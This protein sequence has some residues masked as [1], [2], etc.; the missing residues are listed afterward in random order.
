[1]KLS[2]FNG[3]HL[4]SQFELPASHTLQ[5][6]RPALAGMDKHASLLYKMA[7][8]PRMGAYEHYGD[9]G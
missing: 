7:G 2:S 1:M 4:A 8:E 5:A 3:M 9:Q 6:T